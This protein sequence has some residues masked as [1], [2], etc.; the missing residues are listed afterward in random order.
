M[1]QMS[2]QVGT[3]FGSLMTLLAGFIL[4]MLGLYIAYSASK[5]EPG[6]ANLG[7]FTPIGAIIAVIGGVMLFSRGE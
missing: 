7:L 2:G 6:L 4:L 3:P 5:T 1:I